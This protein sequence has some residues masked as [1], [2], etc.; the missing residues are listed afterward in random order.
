M[1]GWFGKGAALKE[2]NP[3]CNISRCWL[4]LTPGIS[5]LPQ[6]EEQAASVFIIPVLPLIFS[7]RNTLFLAY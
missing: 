2:D 5:L 6:G 3:L 7:G 4:L 1:N